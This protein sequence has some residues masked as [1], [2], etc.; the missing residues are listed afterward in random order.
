MYR[1]EKALRK[2][3]LSA[4]GVLMQFLFLP[5]SAAQAA[6]Q[7]H[8]SYGPFDFSVSIQSL[9]VFAKEGKVEPDLA[10]IVNRLKP[11]Q[12]EQI[13]KFLTTR[14]QFSPVLMAQFFYSSL[15]ETLLTYMG[16]FIQDPQYQNGF[17]G[18]RAALIQAAA[19]KSGL[20]AISFIRQ[21]PSDVRLNT[22]AILRQLSE[23][24]T[25]RQDTNNLVESLEQT[26]K[27]VDPQSQSKISQLPN[28]QTTGDISYVKQM[29]NFQDQRRQRQFR[30]DIYKPEVPGT[31]QIPVVLI[32]NGLA[33]RIDRYD[34]LAEH[35]ASHGFAVVI[36]QHIDSDDKQQQDF[37]QGLSPELF[38][39]TA[40]IDRPLDISYVLDQLQQLNAS[41]FQGRL[42]L[43]GV[44]IFGN[45]FGGDTALAVAGAQINFQ[46]LENDCKPEKPLVNLSLLVQCQALKLPR[47]VYN[48]RDPRIKAASVLFPSSST[49]Y[50]KSGLRQINIPLLWGAVTKDVFSSL[51]LEQSPAFNEVASPEK[52]FVV[53]KGID[54]LNLNFFALRNLRSTQD[55]SAA[56]LTTKE[57]E[58]AKSYLKAL[59]LAFFQ[60]HLA[61]R[62]EFRSYLTPAYAQTMDDA[63]FSLIFVKAFAEAVSAK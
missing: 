53:A 22:R 10:L 31:S 12:R 48:V 11:S 3:F 37:L 34:Y 41:A 51:V 43:K 28:L 32:T 55:G 49:L 17:Y 25:L 19:D 9:E 30:V 61:N 54:H 44:G 15:G 47:K 5:V 20:S 6:K 40:F 62:P 29:M 33:T 16:N 24:K 4:L 1:P 46:Q 21:Y 56:G 42:D 63:T 60:V 23:I 13:R 14:Y 26:A 8:F 45:S 18:V 57:P 36:P 39:T 50:G 35:L 7:V 58:S 52:Y 2:V 59:N 38:K 27:R